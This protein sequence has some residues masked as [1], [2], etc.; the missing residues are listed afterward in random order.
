MGAVSAGFLGLIR[1]IVAPIIH[2]IVAIDPA[3]VSDLNGSDGSPAAIPT[4]TGCR[5]R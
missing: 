2:R 3:A 1:A 4:A 5:C